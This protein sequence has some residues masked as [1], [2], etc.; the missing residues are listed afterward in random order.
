MGGSPASEAAS[1]YPPPF[2]VSYVI[3]SRSTQSNTQHVGWGNQS[4]AGESLWRTVPLPPSTDS[5]RQQSA[6]PLP[7]ESPIL[8][9]DPQVGN[10]FFSIIKPT[11]W[12]RLRRAYYNYP[13]KCASQHASLFW[14]EIIPLLFIYLFCMSKKRI[15]YSWFCFRYFFQLTSILSKCVYRVFISSA[16]SIAKKKY[17]QYHTFTGVVYSYSKRNQRVETICN[18][19]VTDDKRWARKINCRFQIVN[20]DS[21]GG[22]LYFTFNHLNVSFL[23][24]KKSILNSTN[25]ANYFFLTIYFESPSGNVYIS[26]DNF[27]SWKFLLVCCFVTWMLTNKHVW[28]T[29]PRQRLEET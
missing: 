25:G 29:D 5:W 26:G 14:I 7:F 1:S 21:L 11:T 16:Y 4:R 6:P 18:Q 17:N 28:L 19:R 12:E 24:K 13:G 20:V 23:K 2:G 10:T 22:I 27:L 15:G 3:I 8:G 9:W